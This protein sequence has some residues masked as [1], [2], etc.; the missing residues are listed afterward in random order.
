MKKIYVKALGTTIL[1]GTLVLGVGNVANAAPKSTKEVKEV[2]TGRTEQKRE[3]GVITY[4]SLEVAARNAEQILLSGTVVID[5]PQL[6]VKVN[7][8]DASVTKITDKTWSYSVNLDVTGLKGDSTFAIEA[9]TIYANGRPSQD[10]HTYAKTASQMVHIPYITETEA[11]NKEWTSYDRETNQFT[12]SYNLV[13]HWSRGE[14][15]ALPT[16]SVTVAGTTD[17]FKISGATLAGETTV[18]TAFR[19]FSVSDEAPVWSFDE[20]TK[21]YSLT[22]TIFKEDSKGGVT[23]ETITRTGLTSGQPATIEVTVGDEFGTVTQSKEFNVPVAPVVEVVVTDIKD[24]TISVVSHNKEQSK[25]IA[26]YKLVYSTGVVE[27]KTVELGG[28]IS[29][30]E[31]AQNSQSRDFTITEGSKSLSFTVTVLDN[32]SYTVTYK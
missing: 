30:P 25:V 32:G 1:A 3:T 29:K 16:T 18:P 20:T 15:E 9:Y 19:N 17:E 28:T 14:D 13:N 11:V 23:S 10:V 7:G 22:F 24:L 2:E 31:G 4:N 21:T 12:L 6:V 27:T 8:Q 26:T 5:G